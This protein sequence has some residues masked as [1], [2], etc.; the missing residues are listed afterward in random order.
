[1]RSGEHRQLLAGA[2]PSQL[3]PDPCPA[4]AYQGV[5]ADTNF[6]DSPTAARRP[7]D[8]LFETSESDREGGVKFSH[9]QARLSAAE[10]H[11][12]ALSENA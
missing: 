6:S 8:E 10:V 11:A 5:F 1:M 4:H 7:A 9:H 2:S 12:Q 3:E